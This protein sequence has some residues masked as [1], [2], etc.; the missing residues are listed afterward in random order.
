LNRKENYIKQKT[1]KKQQKPSSLII[2]DNQTNKFEI[3]TCNRK[4]FG[5]TKGKFKFLT[6]KKDEHSYFITK[7]YKYIK[8]ICSITLYCCCC[9]CT[10]LF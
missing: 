8:Y 10:I 2:M 6:K 7:F 4:Y 9:L 3:K 5:L 1:I